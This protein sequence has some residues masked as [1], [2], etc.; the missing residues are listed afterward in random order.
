MQKIYDYQLQNEGQRNVSQQNYM[1]NK[2]RID[3]KRKVQEAI[4][5][6]KKEEAKQ[7]KIIRTQNDQKKRHMNFKIE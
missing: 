3:E 5:L 6:S 7:S 1:L 2:Q 4:F